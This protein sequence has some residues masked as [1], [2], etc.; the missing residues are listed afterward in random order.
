MSCIRRLF[1]RRRQ[2]SEPTSQTHPSPQAISPISMFSGVGT[3]IIDGGIFN[4]I[5]VVISKFSSPQYIFKQYHQSTQEIRLQI[6]PKKVRVLPRVLRVGP[7]VTMRRVLA[8]QLEEGNQPHYSTN[9]LCHH[10]SC[11]LATWNRFDQ[12]VG[13]IAIARWLKQY[14]KGMEAIGG[15]NIV[16]Y[17]AVRRRRGYLKKNV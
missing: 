3:V 10:V 15:S 7:A 1:T 6:H 9:K 13:F 16:N 11:S 12:P 4:I 8:S 17:W 14:Q 2:V 5:N